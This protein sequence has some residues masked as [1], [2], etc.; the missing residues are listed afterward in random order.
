ML[1]LD[2]VEMQI[3]IASPCICRPWGA[4]TSFTNRAGNV[5]RHIRQHQGEVELCTTAWAKM[6]ESIVSFDLLPSH[7]QTSPADRAVGHLEYGQPAV[8]SV[9]L[10]EAP[11]AFISA[12]N[13]FIKTQ[14]SAACAQVLSRSVMLLSACLTSIECS[15]LWQVQD[16]QSA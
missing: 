7:G 3:N 11:G 14:R 1:T 4:H 2:K 16:M 8:G 10:C 9:H 5:V 6:Y 12:T 13:H 15:T